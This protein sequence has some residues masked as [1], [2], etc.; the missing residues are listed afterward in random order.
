MHAKTHDAALEALLHVKGFQFEGIGT[1]AVVA[2]VVGRKKFIYDIWGDTVNVASRME[3]HGEAGQ[4][5][6]RAILEQRDLEAG[7][8]YAREEVVRASVAELD[9]Q[10]RL[11]DH[12]GM[13]PES[14]IVVHV[15]SADAAS[16][17]ASPQAA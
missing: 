2:G 9:W 1:G 11:F 13:G 17:A 6:A 14:V 5:Q 12:M 4:V 15:G 7:P 8:L 16:Q 3:S 10:A